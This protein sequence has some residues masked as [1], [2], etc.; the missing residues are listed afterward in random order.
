M[1][2]FAFNERAVL[3]FCH[4]VVMLV[5]SWTVTYLLLA[6]YQLDEREALVPALSILLVMAIPVQATIS[7]LF[8]MYQGLWRYASLPDV[9]RIVVASHHGLGIE[10]ADEL[11]NIF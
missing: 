7:T 6:Q 10:R 9:Q 3:A 4:D 5:V 8:G 11:N 2:R 1:K